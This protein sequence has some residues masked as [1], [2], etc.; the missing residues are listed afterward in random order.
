MPHENLQRYVNVSEDEGLS[1]VVVTGP[2]ENERII[3]ESRYMSGTDDEFADVAFMVDENFHGLGI[4]TFLLKHMIEIAKEKGIKGFKADVLE[5][6]SP[7]LAVFN[8]LPYVVRKQ[9]SG[10]EISLRFRFDELK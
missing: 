9:I 5:S 1:L 3:A 10:G 6:N 7:M 4:A 8:K 2:R